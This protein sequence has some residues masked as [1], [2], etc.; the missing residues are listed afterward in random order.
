MLAT[1]KDLEL[2]KATCLDNK[3]ASYT[4]N[5]KSATV[6]MYS[7]VCDYVSKNG[8][9]LE[10]RYD[11]SLGELFEAMV[12]RVLFGYK[13]GY[14]SKAFAVDYKMNKN[15]VAVDVKVSTNSKDLCTPIIKATKVLFIT[16][17]GA[18]L[19]NKNVIQDIMNNLED[20]KEYAKATSKG[21][22]LKC[23]AIALGQYQEELSKG[24]GF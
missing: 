17:K 9:K 16:P 8:G 2:L 12:K 11:G 6:Y 10:T 23:S 20:Y 15:T 7:L 13:T 19:I 14:Y 3:G 1:L 21:F 18:Y 24:L 22:R 5:D 4:K